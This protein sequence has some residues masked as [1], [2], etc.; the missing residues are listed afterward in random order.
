MKSRS[1][2]GSIQASSRSLVLYDSRIMYVLGFRAYMLEGCSAE[3]LRG[4]GM[5]RVETSGSM[6]LKA[7]PAAP[8]PT[9]QQV[10]TPQP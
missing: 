5:S 3:D 1:C 4:L 7:V 9:K 6:V 8:I 2:R 10:M